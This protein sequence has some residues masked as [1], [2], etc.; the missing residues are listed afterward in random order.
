MTESTNQQNNEVK[1]ESLPFAAPCK[2]LEMSAPIEWLKLGWEDIKRAPVPSLSYG[3]ML[4]VFSYLL[5]FLALTFGNL[6]VLLSLLSGFIFTG[7]VIALGFYDISLQ[8]QQGRTPSLKHAIRTSI[9]HIGNEMLFATFLIII[10][11][12][13]ARAVSIT[14]IFFPALA[15]P[16]LADKATFLIIGFAIGTLFSLFIFCIS[17]FSLTMI[18][19]R[20]ADMV[21]AVV[22]SFNAVLRNKAVM[23]LWALLIVAAVAVGML[24]AFIGLG[25][26]LPLLGH[27]TWHAYQETI[28]SSAWPKNPDQDNTS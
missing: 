15:S 1:S 26:T 19:D 25:L 17:A 20:K 9:R 24:T 10:F 6:V 7:P 5:V 11:L 18:M 8:L 22:T 23:L 21:T 13:W 3:A 14:H 16:D 4:V 28:D 12:V 2:K 27:A